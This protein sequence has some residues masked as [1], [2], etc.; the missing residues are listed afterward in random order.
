MER[1]HGHFSHFSQSY[2]STASCLCQ[3]VFY[4]E[5][6]ENGS[7]LHNYTLGHDRSVFLAFLS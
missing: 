7:R 1:N 6:I 4:V 3:A 2:H 5:Q